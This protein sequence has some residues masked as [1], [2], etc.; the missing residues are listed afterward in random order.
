[1]ADPQSGITITLTP[2]VIMWMIGGLVSGV[3][4]LANFARRSMDRKFAALSASV[5]RLS[6]Y[7][8]NLARTIFA[9]LTRLH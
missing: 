3:V 1:M 4:A 8:H 2:A 7:E 6:V 9:L 5:Q